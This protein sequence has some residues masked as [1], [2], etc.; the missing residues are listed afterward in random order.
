M[1]ASIIAV[2][3]LLPAALAAPSGDLAVKNV[4]DPEYYARE[5]TGTCATGKMQTPIDLPVAETLPGVPDDL[6]TDVKMPVV[7]APVIKNVG[8][9]MQVRAEL[10]LEPLCTSL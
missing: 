9:A 1:A 6:V 3:A 8:S 2:A 5:W 4:F 10:S 7:N